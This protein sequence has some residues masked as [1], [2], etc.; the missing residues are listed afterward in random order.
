MQRR[1]EPS[2]V[3][4]QA[5]QSIFVRR[6]SALAIV[7]KGGDKT[8]YGDRAAYELLCA[9]EALLRRDVAADRLAE[10]VLP[11]RAFAWPSAGLAFQR[12]RP[13]FPFSAPTFRHDALA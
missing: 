1:T 11:I 10:P 8:R 6:W 9:G 12:D 13:P 5:Y 7:L 4:Y 2:T 3:A